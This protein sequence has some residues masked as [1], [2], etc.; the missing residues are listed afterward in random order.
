MNKFLI[1]F[2]IIAVFL[3]VSNT[4]KVEDVS[5]QIK[6][7]FESNLE[8]V[9]DSNEVDPNMPFNPLD[10][11]VDPNWHN[12]CDSFENISLEFGIMQQLGSY[13]LN[14]TRYYQ[15]GFMY[16]Y[17]WIG[18][19]SNV[20]KIDGGQIYADYFDKRFIFEKAQED[21]LFLP[22]IV[23]DGRAKK[24]LVPWPQNI[25]FYVCPTNVQ[26]P[27]IIQDLGSHESRIKTC[28]DMPGL[29]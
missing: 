20:L 6:D 24:S 22:R 5:E 27:L 17:Y 15:G 16:H 12:S 3:Y 7:P 1:F 19:G 8:I 29:C 18:D 21:H 28:A 9:D 23:D 25:S 26:P 11:V 13:K 14:T 10:E 4:D 2:L